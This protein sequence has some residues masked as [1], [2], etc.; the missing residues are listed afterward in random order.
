MVQIMWYN[1][2]HAFCITGPLCGE[3]IGHLWPPLQRVSNTDPWRF[4]C[5]LTDQAVKQPVPLPVISDAFM[6]MECHC[7]IFL[8]ECFLGEVTCD[9]GSK[10]AI[11]KCTNA[12]HQAQTR[13]RPK[14]LP[15]MS[16]SSFKEL[17]AL[18]LPT[19]FLQRKLW[20][21]LTNTTLIYYHGCLVEYRHWSTYHKFHDSSWSE[22][23]HYKG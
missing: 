7:N 12:T 3:C 6:L 16:K 2:K 4:H 19:S 20:A 18:D 21:S 5:T 15:Y 1:T 17:D 8:E 22:W 23:S 9:F 10:S 14:W 11:S 13:S